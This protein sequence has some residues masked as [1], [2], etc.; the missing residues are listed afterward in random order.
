MRIAHNRK[1]LSGQTI[2]SWQVIEIDTSVKGKWLYYKAKCL[3]CGEVYSVR[4]V[5]I[6]H[7]TSK[8]CVKCGCGHAHAA[9]KGQI[10]T[11][12]TPRESAL[13]YTFLS[14]RK[15]S[16]KRG[17]EWK[18]S[19]QQVYDLILKNCAY[20]N[21]EPALSTAPLKHKQLSQKRVAEAILV[22]NGIDRIDSS[23]GYTEDNVVPCCER[24][25][26]AKLDMTLDEFRTWAATLAAHMLKT[27]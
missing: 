10:R 21:S 4:G 18:L 8:R 27:C 12:R 11:K 25:N 19:E 20:C 3:E 1:D 22:R 16:R 5:N 23:K 26:R 15:D 6:R 17:H 24:C 13:Y 7:G 9:Q 2:N 14:L